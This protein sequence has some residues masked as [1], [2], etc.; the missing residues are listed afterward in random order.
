MNFNDFK[1]S[2]FNDEHELHM[3]LPFLQFVASQCDH[4]TEFGFE[5]AK[6]AVALISGC[7]GKVVSYDIRHTPE[8]DILKKMTLPCEWEFHV[9]DTTKPGFV[10]EPTDFLFI[11]TYHKYDMTKLELSQCNNVR[12]YIG[13]HDTV[14]HGEVSIHQ[15]GKFPGILPALR[16]FLADHPEWKIVYEV[17]FNH[18]LILL[19]RVD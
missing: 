9:Q 17:N 2:K 7:R 12:K 15:D 16:E 4:V 3:H 14:S 11:D 10:I 19:Q 18:G 13:L 5:Y 6:S 8:V 1:D